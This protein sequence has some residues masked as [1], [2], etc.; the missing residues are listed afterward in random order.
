MIIDKNADMIGGD[1]FKAELEPRGNDDKDKHVLIQLKTGNVKLG[2]AIS[3]Y[4]IDDL[5]KVLVATK[6]YLNTSDK[7]VKDEVDVGC[8]RYV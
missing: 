2:H 1:L 8:Y 3:A 6:V 7:F 5:I 4:W